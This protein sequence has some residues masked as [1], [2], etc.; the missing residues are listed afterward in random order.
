M[1]PLAS[2]ELLWFTPAEDLHLWSN[3]VESDPL[4]SWTLVQL[5]QSI[6][7]CHT[8]IQLWKFLT[9]QN[10][11]VLLVALWKFTSFSLGILVSTFWESSKDVFLGFFGPHRYYSI[12]WKMLLALGSYLGNLS[13]LKN[14]TNFRP[15]FR[16]S[17][18][19]LKRGPDLTGLLSRFAADSF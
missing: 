9:R 10:S 2:V 13:I 6:S 3:R 16:N 11:Q 15:V 18:V 8:V 5:F 7:F 19:I 12:T 1:A 4:L 14:Q 17:I